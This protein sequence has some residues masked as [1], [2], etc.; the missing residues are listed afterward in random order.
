MTDANMVIPFTS[1]TTDSDA[2]LILEQEEYLVPDKLTMLDVI[3]I[4]SDIVTTGE[5]TS[6]KDCIM[7]DDG[8]SFSAVV[9]AYPYPETLIYNTG[10]VNGLLSGPL[11]TLITKTETLKFSLGN[12]ASLKYPVHT[13]IRGQWLSNVYDVGGGITSQPTVLQDGRELSVD[14]K[15]YGTYE[16][17]YTTVVDVYTMTVSL[18]LDAI[19]NFFQSVFYAWFDGGVELLDIDPPPNAEENWANGVDCN[20]GVVGGSNL[21]IINPDDDPYRAPTVGPADKTIDLDYCKDFGNG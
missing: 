2:Y 8:M 13:F 15:V 21:I 4:L 1:K 19:E 10:A 6:S 18:I 17:K 5:S 16:V 9:L 20:G 3:R 14:S 11:R 12:T 7:S